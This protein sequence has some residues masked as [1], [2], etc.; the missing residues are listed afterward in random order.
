[1]STKPSN[2]WFVYVLQS[3]EERVGK[4]GQPLPGFHYVGATTDP[5]RRLREHNG[6]LVGGGKY[7][8]QHRPWELR[9]VFGPF[10]N[11][12]EAMKAERALKKGKRGPAR[13]AWSPS[14]SKWCR[15]LGPTDPRVKI[16]NDARK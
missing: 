5:L 13:V 2:P 15:G 1:M 12:S 14:D 9:A 10:K 16:A 6:E 11:Q 3:L 8:S 7:T 4:R